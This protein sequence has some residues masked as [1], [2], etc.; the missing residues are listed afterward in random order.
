MTITFE[1]TGEQ[2]KALTLSN[3]SA[4]PDEKSRP[5][6]EEFTIAACNEKL[7]EHVRAWAER[8]VVDLTAAVQAAKDSLTVEDVAALKASIEAAAAASKARKG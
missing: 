6:V 1:L 5:S 4:N 3:E 7:N 8:S 2:E